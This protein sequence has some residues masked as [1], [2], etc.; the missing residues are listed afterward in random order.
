MAM[1]LLRFHE[2]RE[3]YLVASN[4]R[5]A[6]HAHFQERA[7]YMVKWPRAFEGLDASHEHASQVNLAELET[8]AASAREYDHLFWLESSR[9][10]S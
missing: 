10:R 1:S 6:A 4:W 7:D 3:L 5:E 9:G 2:H 8:C